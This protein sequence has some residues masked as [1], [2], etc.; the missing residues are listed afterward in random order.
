MSSELVDSAVRQLAEDAWP[1]EATICARTGDL[2]G[3][4]PWSVSVDNI[5]DYACGAW[6]LVER[7]VAAVL[8][9]AAAELVVRWLQGVEVPQAFAL[10]AELCNLKKCI[11]FVMQQGVTLERQLAQLATFFHDE[12]EEH[13]IDKACGFWVHSR[14]L[15]ELS[16]ARMQA[17][18]ACAAL[19]DARAIGKHCCA[20]P[21]HPSK[22][23]PEFLAEL[24][25]SLQAWRHAAA[26]ST[27]AVPASNN[28]YS[29]AACEPPCVRDEPVAKRI[30]SSGEYSRV[31]DSLRYPN[32]NPNASAPRES[33]RAWWTR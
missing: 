14:R 29:T 21:R 20:L 22:A 5:G 26:A 31:M 6:R 7:D 17:K 24:P 9:E 12:R 19:A 13:A 16:D 3:A 10:R 2:P 4:D 18:G 30:S 32:P 11:Y 25:R 15:T 28:G 8:P 23:T 1:D 27:T 33:T